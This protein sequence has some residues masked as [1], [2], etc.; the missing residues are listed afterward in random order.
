MRSSPRAVRRTF[1]YAALRESANRRF[2]VGA[3]DF[4]ATV[5]ERLCFVRGLEWSSS[6]WITR[7]RTQLLPSPIFIIPAL[8][9]SFIHRLAI[10]SRPHNLANQLLHQAPVNDYALV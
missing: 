3:V 6:W 2:N 10:A 1:C 4:K 8:G 5:A 7:I 9:S